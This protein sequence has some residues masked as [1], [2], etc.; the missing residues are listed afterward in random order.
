MRLVLGAVGVLALMGTSAH[1]GT[2]QVP[3]DYLTI[4]AALAAAAPGDQIEVTGGRHCGAAITR[5]VALVGRAGATIV[6][7]AGSPQV[8][9]LRVGFLLDGA[10]DASPADDTRITGFVFDGAGLSARH[11]A[12]LAFGVLGRFTSGVIVSN[13]VFLGLVQAV[14]NT[15]GD[16][17]VITSNRVRGL[18]TMSGGG[19]GI[20][21]QSA[22][23]DLAALGGA[24]NPRNRPE[25]NTI[26]DNDIEARI[27]DRLDGYSMAAILVVAADR[28]VVSRNHVRL[29]ANPTGRAAAEGVL[30]TSK[31]ASLSDA[32][33][34][35][36]RATVIEENDGRGCE[37]AVMVEHPGVPND[38]GLELR[39]NRGDVV[40]QERAQGQ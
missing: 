37:I 12:P 3:G 28:T 15:A 17:W 7:C 27:P 31:T 26:A 11:R 34:P 38:A 24:L 39:A 30:V 32:H 1:A 2:L 22:A 14:T 29:P 4:T 13:N 36:A 23:G 25:D 16:A 8:A 5:R 20:A 33:A 40:V 10:P 19:V 18:T 21:V 35:G 9:G 6:G